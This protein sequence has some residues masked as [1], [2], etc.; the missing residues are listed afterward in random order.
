MEGGGSAGPRHRRWPHR[1]AR[2]S[3][4]P[5]L[6]AAPL[7]AGAAVLFVFPL[8]ATGVVSLWNYT[9]YS[10]VPDVT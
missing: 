1:P 3:W 9:E 10:L 6:Q 8:L 4:A 7:M 2:R 5:M